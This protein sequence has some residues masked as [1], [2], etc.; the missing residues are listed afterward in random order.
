V[1]DIP[2]SETSAW[3]EIVGWYGTVAIVGAYALLSFDVIDSDS[4]I[5]QLLNLTGSLGIVAISWAKRATQ[6]AVLNIIWA[7]IAL[8]ALVGIAF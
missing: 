8:V 2:T 3:I 5:Y 4:A 6:P 7:A 1:S